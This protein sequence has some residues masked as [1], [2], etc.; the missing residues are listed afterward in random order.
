[1]QPELLATAFAAA[2]EVGLSEDRI[3]VLEG[4]VKGRRR[5]DDL[6]RDVQERKLPPVSVRPAKQN[7]LAYLVFS[8]GTTGLPKGP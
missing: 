3:L 7:T 6:I 5:L 8:S 4:H 2:K 1:V